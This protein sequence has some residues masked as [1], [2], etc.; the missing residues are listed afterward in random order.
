VLTELFERSSPSD[1]GIAFLKNE[2]RQLF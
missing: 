1:T 2:I